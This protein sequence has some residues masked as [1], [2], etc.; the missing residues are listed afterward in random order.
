M[1]TAEHGRIQRHRAWGLS[2]STLAPGCF[3][4]VMATGIVSIGAQLKGLHLLSDVLFWL[5][6]ALYLFFIA[7]TLIRVVRCRDA[8]RT[9]LH[10][11]RRAFGFFTAVAGTNVLAT[12]LIGRGMVGPA[13]ILFAIGIVLWLALGYGIPFTAVLGSSLRPVSKGVNGTWLVWV[14][15]AQSVAVVASSLALETAGTESAPAGFIVFLTLTAVVMWAVGVALYAVCAIAIG[16]RVLRH[17]FGPEHLDAPYWVTM[18]ALAITIVA[19]SRILEL[20][21]SPVIDATRIVVGGSS[22]LLW[23]IATWLVPALIAAGIWRHFVHRLPMGYSAGL[24]SMVFPVGMYAV[25][26]ILLGRSDRLPGIEWIGLHWF[27]VGLVVWTVV[28]V[29]MATS[30]VR[31]VRRS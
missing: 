28:F 24:W 8:V 11:P 17:R 19:G 3:A 20:E 21:N 30:F 12:A 25:A 18:G 9:D 29:A 6:V 22:T 27:W 14:V 23:A 31:T 1:S 13:L 2:P 10:D 15:A 16:V 26:S 7:L 5:A 4:S